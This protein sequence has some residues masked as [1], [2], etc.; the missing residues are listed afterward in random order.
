MNRS[1]Q[2]ILEY[3]PSGLAME[4]MA[5]FHASLPQD[6]VERRQ[7]LN[8]IHKDLQ[9]YH[10]RVREMQRLSDPYYQVT[11]DDFKA[12]AGAF[13]IIREERSDGKLSIIANY[14]D[15]QLALVSLNAAREF[16]PDDVFTL[17]D[18]KGPIEV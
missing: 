14:D 18:E 11:P 13:R 6:E 15:R 16:Y 3:L 5:R 7:H 17:C 1:A 10:R 2:I 4:M 12:P 9:S 8:E